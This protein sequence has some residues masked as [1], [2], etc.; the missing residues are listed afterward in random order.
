[1]SKKV[2]CEPAYATHDAND[3]DIHLRISGLESFDDHFVLRGV[4]ERVVDWAMVR[5]AIFGTD[6][7]TSLNEDELIE[8]IGEIVFR[9]DL[10]QILADR[11]K[12][13]L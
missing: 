12:P 8:K 10:T 7:S 6:G 1:M 5:R 3:V 13:L 11:I 9:H 2:Y 4:R